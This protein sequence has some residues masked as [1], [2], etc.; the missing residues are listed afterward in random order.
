MAELTGL[1]RAYKVRD[2]EVIGSTLLETEI[3][4]GCVFIR[5][6]RAS[7]LPNAEERYGLLEIASSL[8]FQ[9]FRLVVQTFYSMS[10]TGLSYKR[11]G[12]ITESTGDLQWFSEW[13]TF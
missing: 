12:G 9:N 3:E 6:S 8:F 4:S 1:N 5:D 13:K 11:I 10:S 7:D 2:Y